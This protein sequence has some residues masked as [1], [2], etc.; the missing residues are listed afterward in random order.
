GTGLGLSISKR[1]VHLMQGKIA[2]E[3]QLGKGSLFWFT[4]ILTKQAITQSNLPEIVSD[5]SGM[6][7]LVVDDNPTVRRV[8][9]LQLS[10]W[11][12]RVTEAAN[13]NETM[14]LLD[15]SHEQGDEFQVAILDHVM[16]D[17]DGEE[18]GKRIKADPR[19][20]PIDLV[21][22]TSLGKR[23]DAKR[24]EAEGFSA[25]LTKPIKQSLL[26]ECLGMLRGMRKN[27]PDTPP[28]LVT[29]HSIAES[30]RQQ[31]RILIAEDN[32]IS[33]QIM[34]TLL[35]KIGYRADVVENGV[36]A[37]RALEA[38][39]YALVLMDCQMPEMDGYEA[40]RQIRT[41]RANVLQPD[42]PI[43]AVTA[44]ALMGDEALCIQAGMN[45]YISKPLY[46]Q[47]F[48]E[49][50]QKWVAVAVER[51][52]SAAQ[53]NSVKAVA[54]THDCE[55]VS[56]IKIEMFLKSSA[57]SLV[58]LRKAVDWNDVEKAQAASAELKS[59]AEEVVANAIVSAADKAIK[60][61][62]SGNLGLV[63]LLLPLLE[64]QVQKFRKA[65]EEI[66]ADQ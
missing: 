64:E 58:A 13:A 11:K 41:K 35:E 2:V 45:D 54:E 4:V 50:V 32:P 37:L 23:G 33:Q 34:L 5:I 42:I 24:L 25:Y 9:N 31:V 3:S 49:T 29:R 1:L 30:K 20:E 15:E 60:L 28:V 43:I 65:W 39:T 19:F 55:G 8:L 53:P 10:T 27:S 12:C 57:Q 59:A 7:V 46:P 51:M 21:L 26:S 18:L 66:E 16:P 40:S 38:R 6:R 36:E 56:K 47:R 52:A 17:I 63:A 22:L 44:N 14:K 61:L 48:I 62:N